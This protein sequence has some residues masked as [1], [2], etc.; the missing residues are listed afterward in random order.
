MEFDVSQ[1]AW[2]PDGNH[3]G[4]DVDGN[5]ASVATGSP[6]FSLGDGRRKYAWVVFDRGANRLSV[7]VS[8]VGARP[9]DPMVTTTSVNMAPVCM[10]MGSFSGAYVGFAGEGSGGE[11]TA[12][13]NDFCLSIGTARSALCAHCTR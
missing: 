13:V 2:D 12:V 5:P 8:D 10:D 4:I 3:V 11:D 9:A 7:F 6:A 1:E